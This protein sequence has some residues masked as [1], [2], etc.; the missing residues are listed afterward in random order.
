MD[1]AKADGQYG[2]GLAVF[3]YEITAKGDGRG[4][5]TLTL[6]IVLQGLVDVFKLLVAVNSR[7]HKSIQSLGF[8][9]GSLGRSWIFLE[10]REMCTRA[11]CFPIVGRTVVVQFEQAHDKL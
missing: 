2:T 11:G 5:C 4:C 7:F 1:K 10:G 6:P 8:T 3:K 9:W